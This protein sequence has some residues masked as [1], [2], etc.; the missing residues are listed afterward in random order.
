MGV[1][2]AVGAITRVAATGMHFPGIV[3]QPYMAMWVAAIGALIGG[4]AAATGRVVWGAVVG[5]VL[6]GMIFGGVLSL[7]ALFAYLGVSGPGEPVPL[8]P[9]WEVVVI[10]AIPGAIGAWVGQTVAR[11]AKAGHSRSPSA[12]SAK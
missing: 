3:G 7:A 4:V 6:S 11:R 5:G 2:A 12:A 9:L 8:P 1:G 10:G